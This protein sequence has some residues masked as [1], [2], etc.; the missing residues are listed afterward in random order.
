MNTQQIRPTVVVGVDGSDSALRAVRWGAAEAGRRRALLRLVTAF[1]W[2]ADRVVH[3]AL[4]QRYRHILLSRARSQLDEAAELAE[5]EA[6]DIEVDREVVVGHPM[7]VLGDEARRAQLVVIGD[8][9]LG[10]IDG[11]VVGSV[12][13]ALAAHASS[14]VVVVRGPE[15]APSAAALPVVVGVDEPSTSGAAV[16]FAF[17]A[18]AARQVPLVAV[19]TWWNLIADPAMAPLLDWDAIETDEH[20]VLSEQLADAV[21]KYPDVPVERLVTRDRPA[22]SLLEQAAR[23]QLVVVGSRGRGPVSGLLL[24]SVSHAVLHRA[25]CPVAVVRPDVEEERP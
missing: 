7:A 9:G 8:S 22:H 17:D 16:A 4:A 2:E 6:P 11:L 15:P 23:A 24:G 20:Q 18:A 19:H 13:V 14:P 10:R 1:G 21:E 12:A 3:A 5:R 25:P